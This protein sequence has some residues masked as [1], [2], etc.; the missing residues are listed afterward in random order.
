MSP[1]RDRLIGAAAV[2]ALTALL[3]G[4]IVVRAR[5]RDNDALTVALQQLT[6][7]SE[8]PRSA[9]QAHLDR[10]RAAFAG[11]A[12]TYAVDPLALIGLSLLEP[13]AAHAGEAAPPAPAAP[14]TQAQVEAHA[15]ALLAR[16]KS[17]Q[18]VEFLTNAAKVQTLSR[19]AAA[20]L[21]F[22]T[23]W[24]A[25]RPTSPAAAADGD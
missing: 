23:R 22:A 2:L 14:R 13:L 4:L 5:H 17:A 7:A 16:A 1:R 19:G 24:Q 21:R 8:S 3:V 15:R 20:L 6:F 12:G 9:R 18:A 11:A 25:A 10:A